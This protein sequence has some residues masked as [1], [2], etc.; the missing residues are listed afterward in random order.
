MSLSHLCRGTA[1]VGA[2][3][4]LVATAAPAS[5]SLSP[6]FFDVD[7]HTSTLYTIE[8][9]CALGPAFTTD[10]RFITYAVHA[11]ARAFGPSAAL[12]TSVQ[13]TVYDSADDTRRYGGASGA[14]PGPEAHAVGF[15]TVPVGR[16][17]AVCVTGGATYLDGYTI[18]SAKTCP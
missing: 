1:A 10:P 5:A 18:G 6:A 16:I 15:A 3:A 11:G 13:C 7:V 8:A 4:V 9:D 14:L 12:A 17:P 2:A